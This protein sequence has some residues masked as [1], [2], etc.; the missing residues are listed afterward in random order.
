MEH[1]VISSIMKFAEEN[2]IICLEQ[3][4]FRQGHFYESHFL[5]MTNK[6]TLS[7]EK[8]LQRDLL[9]MAFSE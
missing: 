2:N 5:G 9:N 8:G 3:H 7:L 6:I 4:G 1:I